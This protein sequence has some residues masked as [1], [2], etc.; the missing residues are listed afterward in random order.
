MD[1]LVSKKTSWGGR[2]RTSE[3]RNQNP[4]TYRLSTPQTIDSVFTVFPFR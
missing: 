3:Y 4:V 1:Y 2:I